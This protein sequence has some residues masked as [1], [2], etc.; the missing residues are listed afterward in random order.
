MAD[1]DPH[2]TLPHCPNCAARQK[3]VAS[4]ETS[5]W[6]CFE[7]GANGT[8]TLAAFVNAADAKPV[9]TDEPPVDG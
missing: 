9:P 3:A 4:W 8:F 7:C 5:K 1:H 6:H 2:F